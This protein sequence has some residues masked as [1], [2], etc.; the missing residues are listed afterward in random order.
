MYQ[1]A[2]MLLTVPI[3]WHR[4]IPPLSANDAGRSTD[5]SRISPDLSL[6]TAIFRSAAPQGPGA[7]FG[8]AVAPDHKN[9]PVA[10]ATPQ[11]SSPFVRVRMGCVFY[12]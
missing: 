4:D 3:G 2:I 9:G 12:L 8:Q 5:A 11:R 10:P 1:Y 6:L 7:T